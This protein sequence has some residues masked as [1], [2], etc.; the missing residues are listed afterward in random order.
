M[1]MAVLH[2]NGQYRSRRE[3][4][5]NTEKNDRNLLYSRRLLKKK[6]KMMILMKMPTTMMKIMTCKISITS[7]K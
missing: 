5:V 7:K 1:V 4:N 2:S 6:K 3:K